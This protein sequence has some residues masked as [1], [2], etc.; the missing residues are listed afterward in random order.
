M[1]Q[2]TPIFVQEFDQKPDMI[3]DVIHPAPPWATPKVTQR[4]LYA[5]L[6]EWE[7]HGKRFRYR[8]PI[9]VKNYTYDNVAMRQDLMRAV[10]ESMKPSIDI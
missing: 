1:A 9:V 3:I 8:I 10:F 2:P 5:P 4:E 6:F 7:I